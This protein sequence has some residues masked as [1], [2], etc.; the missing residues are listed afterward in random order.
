MKIA[1]CAMVRLPTEKAHGL[2]IMKTASALVDAGV[3]LELIIPDRKNSIETDPFEYYHVAKNFP[4]T[5][6]PVRDLITANRFGLIGYWLQSYWFVRAVLRHCRISAF[7]T[8]DLPLAYWL[9]KTGQPLFYEIHSLPLKPTWLHK[10]TWHRAQGI[11]VIT[12]GLKRELIAAGVLAEKIMVERD[13]V[14]VAQFQD[15]PPRSQSR[16]A[17]DIPPDQKVVV[18][19]GHLYGWKGADILAKAGQLLASEGIHTYIVGGTDEEIPKFKQEFS[20]SV[21]HVIGRRPHQEMPQ[22][23]SAADV[24]AIPNSAKYKIGAIYTSPMKLF[25]YMAADRPIVATDVPSLREVLKH[26]SMFAPPDDPEGLANAIRQAFADYKQWQLLAH[27]LA[28]DVGEYSWE[29][30]GKRIR[31]F[32]WTRG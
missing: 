9:G 5:R 12:D 23:L 10:Q 14:D 2:Q 22:W 17:L 27:E 26:K 30:R 24:L 21:V 3:D 19:T 4:I 25:E 31:E 18:Y 32:L 28:N 6:L 15:V 20:S 8:R 11:I 29:N 7:Y 13:S 16:V 1:Y